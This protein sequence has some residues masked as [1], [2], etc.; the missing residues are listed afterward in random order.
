MEDA[1]LIIEAWRLDHNETRLHM[2][3]NDIR[4]EEY[5]RQSGAWNAKN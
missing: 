3:L 5:A 1:K 4:P 2:A